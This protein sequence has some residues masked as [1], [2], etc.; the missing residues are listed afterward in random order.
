[1]IDPEVITAINT[2]DERLE[3]GEKRINDNILQHN[4]SIAAL[5]DVLG[6]TV[7]QRL[8]FINLSRKKYEEFQNQINSTQSEK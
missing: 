6:L 4:A 1:M 3:E 5:I 8:D 2:F 7:D